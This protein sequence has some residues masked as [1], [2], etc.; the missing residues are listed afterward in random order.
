ML[1]RPCTDDYR[2]ELNPPL[3]LTILMSI[4]ALI[5]LRAPNFFWKAVNFSLV[6]WILRDC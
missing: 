2:R 1:K 3:L 5:K 6:P 4:G